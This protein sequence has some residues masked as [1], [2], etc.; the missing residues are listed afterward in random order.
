VIRAGGGA[1][2]DRVSP[3]QVLSALANSPSAY[4]RTVYYGSLDQLNETV[5][6]QAVVPP[7]SLTSLIGQTEMP[8]IYQFNFG[9]QQQVGAAMT[10]DVSYV[11]SLSR[12]LLWDRDINP[13][14]A[15]ATDLALHPENRD[16]TIPWI[17]LPWSLLR[18][19]PGYGAINMAEFAGTDDYNSL[20]VNANRRMAGGIQIYGTYTLSKNLGTVPSEGAVVS[21]FFDPRER[22]YGPIPWDM[23]HVGSL[24]Y[25]WSLPKP[26]KY[27]PWHVL[28]GV[29]DGWELGG[30]A[31]F[32]SG[33]PFTPG[34]STVDGMDITGTPSE[35]ARVSVGDPE[36][37]P[38]QRFARTPQGSFGNA[39]VGILRNPGICNWDLSTSR[40]LKFGKGW[41]LNL[42][43]ETY[44]TFNHT[45]F[46]VVSSNTTFNQSGEQVDPMFLQPVYA[47]SPRRIQFSMRLSR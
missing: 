45:Q 33:T 47:R 30:I 37:D 31:Q 3:N 14:P 12:H 34:F 9:L 2:F 25:S 29:T 17:T 11:G 28:A 4:T 15:G 21:P 41:T 20:Q 35:A 7:G 43:A 1:F 26:G 22:N 18:P 38:A 27:L 39:G 19:Y 46:A 13:V 8:T 36:A 40:Q 32:T 23:R 42:R 16:P 24:R 10:V 5:D 6:R 44:N